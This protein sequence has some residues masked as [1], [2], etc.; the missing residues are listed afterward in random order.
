MADEIK[1]LI[2]GELTEQTLEKIKEGVSDSMSKGLE[3]KEEEFSKVFNFKNIK[4][5]L[6]NAL[7]QAWGNSSKVQQRQAAA[8]NKYKN[9]Q[10]AVTKLVNTQNK[11]ISGTGKLMGAVTKQG[12][13]GLQGMLSNVNPYLAA[14][15]V[16]AETA[17]FIAD[18]VVRITKESSKFVGQGSL[19][20]DKE[21]MSMMQR[22]GQT[23]TQAQATQRALGDLGLN[24]DDL[25]QGRL[26]TEQAAAFAEI[27]QRE[28]E[29]LEEINEVAGPMFK[30][31]QQVSLGFT[32][33]LRDI[34]DYITKVF[35][36]NRGI[37]SLVG[38]VKTLMERMGPLFKGLMNALN[39]IVSVVADIIAIVIDLVSALSPIVTG[40]LNALAPILEIIAKII[41]IIKR[42]LSPVLLL[43]GDLFGWLGVGA[44]ALFS[45]LNPVV[46]WFDMIID[47]IAP[48]GKLI[49]NLIGIDF[50]SLDA[51]NNTNTGIGLGYQNSTANYNNMT[52]NNYLF[53]SQSM[54]QSSTSPKD[55]FSNSYS[56][57]ND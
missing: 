21:T 45:I 49:G 15:K 41:N 24:F 6:G 53:G 42:V 47:M 20:A 18:Q 23:A 37:E 30:S 55:L 1:V 31:F 38:S 17:K 7:N 50:S 11:G 56:L 46:E 51:A 16:A 3:G 27:R 12:I 35:A 4:K 32:L 13:A 22:T 44:E 29:K 39:P 34:S 2:D 48:F 40:F 8:M 52:T 54:S 19:F 25:Q 28:L 10:S 33:L 26:T 57:I 9:A 14:A 36:N 5:D 43:I